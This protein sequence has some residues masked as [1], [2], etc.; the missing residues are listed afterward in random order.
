MSWL[1]KAVEGGKRFLG[2]IKGGLERGLQLFNKGKE[3]YAELKQ[4]AGDLPYVG[5][6]A[7]NLI[8]EAERRIGQKY[9]EKTGRNLAQDVGRGESLAQ[10]GL[11]GI[12]LAEG[13]VNR[14]SRMGAE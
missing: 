2:K 8:T 12:N 13:V 9:T 10:R 5:G 4:R 1:K 11:Q 3:K 14:L 6:A 7:T